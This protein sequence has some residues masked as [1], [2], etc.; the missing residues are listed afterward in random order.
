M[1]GA[2][3]V[4]VATFHSQERAEAPRPGGRFWVLAGDG[5]EDEAE[6]GKVVATAEVPSPST[7]DI[8]VEFF[9]DGSDEEL[10]GY[11]DAAV[12]TD[13][14]AWRGSP[15][16]MVEVAQVPVH[17]TKAAAAVRP[18]IEPIPKRT[19]LGH[20]EP[21]PKDPIIG[22]TEAFLADPMAGRDPPRRVRPE[23][24]EVA[25]WWPAGL[26][27][28]ARR[29]RSVERRGRGRRRPGEARVWLARGGPGGGGVGRI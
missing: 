11:A 29:S 1:E 21:T 7:S 24:E 2:T 12:P 28:G 9:Q 19:L 3:A 5:E 27:P 10:A 16:D 26:W 22:V 6:G 14:Q 23:V 18:W 13:V 15:T 8:V 4:T 25:T 17:R 20:V